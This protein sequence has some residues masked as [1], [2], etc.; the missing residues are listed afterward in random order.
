MPPEFGKLLSGAG[1][2]GF[3]SA[4]SAG[5]QSDAPA[6]ETPVAPESAS[7]SFSRL[8]LIAALA[9][10]ALVAWWLIGNRPSQVV[11]Q[12]KTTA[13]QVAQTLSVDGVDLRSSVQTAL[14]G[15]KTA[16]QGVSD[17]A[18]AQVALPQLQKES[19]DFQKIRDLASK[20]PVDAKGVLASL[21]ASVRP[22]IDELFDKVLAIPGVS[23]IAKPVIDGLRAEL[24]ALGKAKA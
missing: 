7:W 20:L 23:A 19:A 14:A 17:P 5:S 21:V 13:G 6:V 3:E 16:L 22:A 18:S 8:G 2:P 10:A 15:L 9:A 11:E 4:A 1:L 24:D 12:T